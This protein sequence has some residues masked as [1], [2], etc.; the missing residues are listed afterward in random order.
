MILE[1]KSRT[2]ET[3]ETKSF[4]T[5]RQLLAI[6]NEENPYK[7]DLIQVFK[8]NGNETD[9]IQLGNSKFLI[10]AIN[11]L[12]NQCKKID[13]PSKIKDIH[14]IKLL[15]EEKALFEILSIK[16]NYIIKQNKTDRL[17]VETRYSAKSD[18]LDYYS[19]S[20]FANYCRDNEY[21]D[22]ISD[23]K[24][25]L[26][27]KNIS[28]DEER[29]LRIIHNFSDNKFYLRAITS[30]NEYKDFG[31]N[32]SVFVALL[33][34][35]KYMK[36]TSSSI[37]INR[38]YIDDSN[39]YISFALN[40]PKKVTDSLMLE[41][42]L[43]LENDEI[44]RSA[45]SFNGIFKLK[46]K[47]KDKE[48]VIYLNPEGVKNK[49]TERNVDLL[50]YPHRGSVESVF[51]KIKDL[52]GL[53]NFFMSQTHEDAIKISQIE[54]PDDVRKFIS[55]KVKWSKKPEFQAYK[56]KILNKLMSI[57]VDNTFSLFELLRE[58]EELFDHDDI[59]S[60]NFWRSK[61]YE[62]L[63]NKK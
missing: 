8:I 9:V 35:N 61:L 2:Y 26:N 27:K 42:N 5:V 56:A 28:N 53:I 51:D 39:I 13:I 58:V 25:Y 7:K 14:L 59:I 10:D 52:P 1:K 33:A 54:H 24:N 44:K 3:F 47:D 34:I 50:T 49:K 18:L 36:E 11:N 23:I 17:T 55:D 32:F 48:S 6:L 41:F 45:V 20:K 57:S 19:F 37:Y 40:I 31:I 21:G 16:D 43:I 30:V 22:L 12:D 63:V 4:I 29:N 15:D 46:F 38:F 60:I 62:A